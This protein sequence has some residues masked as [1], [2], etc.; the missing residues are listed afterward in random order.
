MGVVYKGV[1][2]VIGKQVA[3]KVLHPHISLDSDALV[4]FL[5]EARTVNTIRHRAIVDIFGY[6]QLPG[7]ASYFVME[8]LDGQDFA[9]VLSERGPL[10]VGEAL[11]W[12]DEALRPL[13]AAHELGIVHRDLKPSNLFL[14]SDPHGAPYVKLLDF[15][16]AKADAL[17]EAT[18][19]R[20]RD[21]IVLGT[22]EYMSPEQVRGEPITAAVDLYA[23]G[24]LLFEF[25][26]RRRPFVA[27]SAAKVMWMHASQPPPLAR[28]FNPSVPQ[29]VDDLIQWLRAKDPRAR[30]VSAAHASRLIAELRAAF[31]WSP[32]SA[33]EDNTDAPRVVSGARL[34]APP[35]P[36]PGTKTLTGQ[37]LGES[38]LEVTPP[39]RAT[40]H[41]AFTKAEHARAGGSGPTRVER[42]TPS[43]ERRLDEQERSEGG[44]PA[45]LERG[46][47]PFL[48]GLQRLAPAALV[49]VG[50]AGVVLGV[51][52]I[53]L[54]ARGP[55]PG[56]MDRFPQ[57]S[58][59]GAS[60][61]PSTP[62]AP[63]PGERPRPPG[64]GTGGGPP[65]PP[66][67]AVEACKGKKR[68]EPCSFALEGTGETGTCFSP[69]DGL[70]MACRPSWAP[71]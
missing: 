35:R 54:L 49:L 9:A 70:P 17:F 34:L 21:S 10:S 4:R 19:P 2:P 3:I 5:G 46:P 40:P 63:A 37:L 26:T 71:Q 20:T 69:F 45:P 31:P 68:D 30:P 41:G 16:I 66:A 39:E 52:A 27:P 1:H 25:L 38:K 44:D 67:A 58:P 55:E 48:A 56:N 51:G 29:G 7:G 50:V 43:G 8:H 59:G 23:C 60:G 47:R 57:R 33:R 53:V 22:P 11:H 32:K 65:S 28:D 62:S 61:G 18:T 36:E 13:T 42:A 12:L 24:I 6:G 14:V 64:T 15:G